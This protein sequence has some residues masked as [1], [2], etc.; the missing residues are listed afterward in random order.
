MQNQIR[1]L[2]PQNP[3][4]LQFIWIKWALFSRVKLPGREPGYSTPCTTDVK[5]AFTTPFAFRAW[6]GSIC[7]Y[8][9]LISTTKVF[10][11]IES[12]LELLPGGMHQDQTLTQYQMC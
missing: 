12:L 10:S 3:I 1:V 4:V 2:I 9:Y 8:P 6:K 7:L 5:N 11:S